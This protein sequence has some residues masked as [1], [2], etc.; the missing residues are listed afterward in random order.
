ME[1]RRNAIFLLV[2]AALLAG[3]GISYNFTAAEAAL[4]E[5]VVIPPCPC[6]TETGTQ[7][8]SAARGNAYMNVAGMTGES[9][10]V[11][12]PNW[13]DVL[14]FSHNISVAGSGSMGS[15]RRPARP[16]HQ[17]ISI[18]KEIDKTSPKLA[19]FCCNG[20]HIPQIEI[21]FC[22]IEDGKVYMKYVLTDVI[23]SSVAP[24][25]SHRA[26]GEFTHTEQVTLRYSKIKWTY[27]E[28]DDTGN[29][30]GNVEAWWDVTTGTGG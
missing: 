19:L 28:Y 2:V 6:P 17:D 24:S 16:Q 26:A 23:I 30:K 21:E 29:P 12:H 1:Q 25:Y 4:M 8:A 5:D 11:N 9:Q 13:I 3:V 27:T 10:D 15:S 22:R 7:G 18:V 14:L 20:T